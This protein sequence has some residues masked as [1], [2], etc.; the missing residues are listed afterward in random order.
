MKK[1]KIL[2]EMIEILKLNNKILT[3]LKTNN[4]NTVEDLW[5]LKRKEVKDFGLSDSEI[6]QITIQLQLYGIDLNKK[7]Y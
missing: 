7:V 2:S 4:I 3:T 6:S 5:N 1:K